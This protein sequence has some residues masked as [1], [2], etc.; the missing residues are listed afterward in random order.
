M[1]IIPPLMIKTNT[2]S[3]QLLALFFAVY[4]FSIVAQDIPFNCDYDAYLFQYNDVY[5]IDLASGSSYLVATDVTPGSINA[6]AYNPT[7]G[8][9]WGSLSTPSKTIV[10]IGKNFTTTS[11]YV[12]ELPTNGRYVGDINTSGVYYLKGGG[13]TFYKIDVNPNSPTYTKH[14]A[15]ETLS[16]SLSIHDWAFNAVDGNLYAVEKTT[17]ILYRI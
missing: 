12:D 4:S 3:K 9:I 7:D 10:R 8:Y 14:L 13:K 16:T 17:N 5:S 11:F 6:A 2:L 1:D 15:T